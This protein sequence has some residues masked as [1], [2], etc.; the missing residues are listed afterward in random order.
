MKRT[1]KGMTVTALA[2]FLSAT[3][4]T[5]AQQRG[6]ETALRAAIKTEMVRG[7]SVAIEQYK[8]VTD[9]YRRSDPAIAAQ[10]LLRM[11][12]AY[13]K[14]GDPH[15]E[16]IYERIVREFG[17]QK[18]TA[19]VAGTWL[20]AIGSRSS[21]EGG[22]PGIHVWTAVGAVNG[23]LSANGRRMAFTGST[24]DPELWMIRGLFAANAVSGRQQEDAVS[25]LFG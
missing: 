13:E 16:S 3:G 11:A 20:A 19:A 21:P 15:A 23:S 9:T 14:L 25:A 6:A 4:L 18:E 17:D 8:R 10:A 2:L 12:Q 22:T 5:L 24:A 1:R 7:V